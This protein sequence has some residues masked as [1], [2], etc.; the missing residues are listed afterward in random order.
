MGGVNF[1]KHVSNP[2]KMLYKYFK[3][4]ERV[5]DTIEGQYIHFET[6]D[7]YNDVFDSAISVSEEDFKR[8]PFAGLT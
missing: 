5:M 3:S 8:M 2:P 6:P 1:R 7:T 4:I